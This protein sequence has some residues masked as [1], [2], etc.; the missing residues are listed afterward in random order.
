MATSIDGE[1][2]EIRERYRMLTHALGMR[3]VIAVTTI[4][5]MVW[6]VT[7]GH[8]VAAAFALVFGLEFCGLIGVRI[9]KD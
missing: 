6:L 4:W 7:E 9:G 3:A 5:A 1:S 8:P 2:E